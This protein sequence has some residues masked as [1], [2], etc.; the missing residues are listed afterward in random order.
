ML[1]WL[2]QYKKLS[3]RTPSSLSAEDSAKLK[4]LE[5][6]LSNF[7]N[8][9]GQTPVGSKEFEARSSLRVDTSYQVRL[10]TVGDFKKAYIRNISGGG[11]FVETSHFAEIGTKVALQLL[12]PDEIQPMDIE[13]SVAWINP[14]ATSSTP[15]GLGLKF[16]KMTEADRKRI[17]KFINLTIENKIKNPET[18]PKS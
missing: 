9:K 8:L 3:E 4:E 12:L 10:N 2:T 13:S 1:Q 14:R 16:L 18:P 11:L 7:I 17:Q 15:Q 5:K 6:K